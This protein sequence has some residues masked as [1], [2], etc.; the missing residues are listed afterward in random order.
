MESYIDYL[1]LIRKQ[2][3]TGI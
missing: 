3:K 1:Y 2:C